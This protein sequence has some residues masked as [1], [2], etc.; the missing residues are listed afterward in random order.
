MS[1]APFLTGASMLPL[2]KRTIP[3]CVTELSESTMDEAIR[4]I[5]TGFGGIKVTGALTP[6]EDFST[7]PHANNNFHGV[8]T[9]DSMREYT[10]TFQRKC[11]HALA[12]SS[13]IKSPASNTVSLT[14]SSTSHYRG[15]TLD[16]DGVVISTDEGDINFVQVTLLRFGF[17]MTGATP[18]LEFLARLTV[19]PNYFLFAVGGFSTSVYVYAPAI[20]LTSKAYYSLPD[21]PANGDS[22]APIYWVNA[23]ITEEDAGTLFGVGLKRW[24]WA[25]SMNF[26]SGT[27]P[28]PTGVANY[29]ATLTAVEI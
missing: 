24:G 19:T 27:F 22:S 12:C 26:N 3:R 11:C 25:S 17:C 9:G 5:C 15:D 7:D 4:A 21:V 13:G 1:A 23:E 16:N 14:D 10:H 8:I 28:Y 18:R 29:T 2:A 6:D 20:G